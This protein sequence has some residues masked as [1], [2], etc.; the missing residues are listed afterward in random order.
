MQSRLFGVHI[1]GVYV[2]AVDVSTKDNVVGF[3]VRSEVVHREN[4]LGYD[5][6]AVSEKYRNKS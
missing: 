6:L 5:V 4:A 3:H 2:D 1:W